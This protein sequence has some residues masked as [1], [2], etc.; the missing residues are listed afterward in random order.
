MQTLKRMIIVLLSFFALL[1]LVRFER[2]NPVSDPKLEIKADKE[3]MSILKSACYDCHSNNTVWPWY[4]NIAPASWMVITDVNGGREWLNFSVWES[5]DEAKKLKLRKLIS[6][7]VLV[8]MPLQSYMSAH[9]EARMTEE[10]RRTIR[11]WTGVLPNTVLMT[12]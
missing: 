7:E 3:V 1:Q 8:A 5:Y 4:S 2:T 9:P 10:Q 6:R 12:E 11:K